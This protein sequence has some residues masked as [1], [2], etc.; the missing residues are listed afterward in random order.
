MKT[1]KEI[2]DALKTLKEVCDTSEDCG[3]CPLRSLNDTYPCT[4]SQPNVPYTWEFNDQEKYWRAF[5]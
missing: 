2:L 3:E 1:Q 5:R 4:F